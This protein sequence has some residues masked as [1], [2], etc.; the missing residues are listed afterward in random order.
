MDL[1]IIIVNYRTF[2]L[3]KDAILS[4]L[5]KDNNFD[6]EIVVVDNNSCDGSVDS[7]NDQFHNEISSGLIKVIE[8][9]SNCGFACANNIAI[10]KSKADFILLLN[11]DTVVLDD[12]LNK[13]LNYIKSHLDIGALG[14]KVVLENGQ[15]DPACKRGFPDIK[16]SFYRL[17]GL[18]KLFPKSP[19]FSR[20]N[21]SYL[22]EDEINEVDSLV[23][24]FMLVRMSSI[25][26]VGLLDETFFM[27]GEDIDWCYRIKEAGWKIIYYPKASIIHFKGSSNH[28]KKN[29]LIY[30]FYRAMKIF[31]DK[32]YKPNSSIFTTAFVYIGIASLYLLKSF[33]NI[34]KR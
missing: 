18:S 5:G 27:Y 22:D 10:R 1:T 19:R 9:D 7:L 4:I 14:C 26:E 30:E 28:K 34:F 6:Y 25:K 31:Y 32:H 29:K 23:G 13:S 20:Y 12:C 15:L 8:N 33:F 2:N 3:T 21:M 17:T 24:A 11:S 16:S